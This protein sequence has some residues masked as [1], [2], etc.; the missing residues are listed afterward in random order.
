MLQR[1]AEGTQLM[2]GLSQSI[3]PILVDPA[4]LEVALTNLIGNARDATDG[5]GRVILETRNIELTAN[6]FDDDQTFVPGDYVLVAVRDSGPGMTADVA[7]RACEPF[8]T[9]KAPGKGSG[10]GLSQVYG[11]VKSAGGHLRIESQP[12]RGTSVLMYFPKAVKPA[13]VEVKSV[14]APAASKT[15]GTEVVLV[16]ED[17][18]DVRDVTSA[19][20]AD[21]GY[22]VREATNAREALELLRTDADV[23][24]LFSDVIMPGGMTGIELVAA[25]RRLRPALKVLLTSGNADAIQ[26]RRAIA[27]E[28]FD[29]I[30]KPYP[31]SDLANKLRTIMRPA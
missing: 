5:S 11:F 22:E 31:H 18:P 17:D 6:L 23:D 2:T 29:I 12:S 9:T 8:F 25:A 7:A 19:A 1:S 13:P 20:V 26:S 24:L 21:L 27:G 10:L 4:Q 14:S 16:V 3:H 15:A 28:D 30:E